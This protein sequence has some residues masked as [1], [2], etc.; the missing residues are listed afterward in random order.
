MMLRPY[1]A[2][3]KEAAFNQLIKRSVAEVVA[4]QPEVDS[5]AGFTENW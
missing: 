5:E 4:E 2:A 1:H 3:H